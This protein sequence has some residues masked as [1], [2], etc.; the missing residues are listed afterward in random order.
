M[1]VPALCSNQHN[2]TR[3]VAGARASIA[4]FL[5]SMKMK[6][7]KCNHMVWFARAASCSDQADAV[8]S[9]GVASHFHVDVCV[10]D[11]AP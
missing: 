1:R 6:G 3:I 8:K 11:V 9:I 10:G 4:V 5:F 2:A 7:K